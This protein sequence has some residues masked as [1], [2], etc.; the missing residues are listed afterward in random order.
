MK[1]T[2]Y[3]YIKYGIVPLSLLYLRILNPP[4][5][6]V[7]HHKLQEGGVDEAH[8]DCIPEVHGS[9]IGYNLGKLQVIQ[10]YKTNIDE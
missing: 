4:G 8:A 9:K 10:F 6:V 1:C 3:T 7:D 2:R 5:Q